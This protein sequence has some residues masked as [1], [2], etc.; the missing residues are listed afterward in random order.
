MNDR[1]DEV[2]KSLDLQYILFCVK[3][4][5]VFAASAFNP[6]LYGYAGRGMRKAFKE[7]F[8]CGCI[9]K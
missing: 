4:Y 5:F 9:K 6:L 8:R 3:Y 2:E 1:F 7:T